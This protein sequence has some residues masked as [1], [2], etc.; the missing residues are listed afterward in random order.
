MC[1]G[2]GIQYGV[3]PFDV[4]LEPCCS[5]ERHALRRQCIGVILQKPRIPLHEGT[6]KIVDCLNS[7]VHKLFGNTCRVQSRLRERHLC[8]RQFVI[9]NKPHH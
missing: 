3:K 7:T 8:G 9:F 1:V 2:D 4:F 5:D 6:V